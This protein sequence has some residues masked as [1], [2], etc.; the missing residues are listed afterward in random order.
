MKLVDSFKNLSI[1]L[2]GNIISSGIAIGQSYVFRQIELDVVAKNK[3]Q[4]EDIAAEQKRLEK[5]IAQSKNQINNIQ[6]KIAGKTSKDIE[7]IF[8]GHT[9]LLEDVDF[10]KN[11]NNLLIAEKVNIEY[12]LSNQIKIL[13]KKF[14]EIQDEFTQTR[15]I[16][17]QDVCY[18]LLRNLLGIEHV[19]TN[20]LRRIEEAVII[21]AERLRPS[22]I[23]L[24]D[25]KKIIGI[26]IEQGSTS[27]HVA[28]ISKSLGIPVVIN[29][30]GITSI[31]KTNHNIIIDGY[32]GIV[33]VNPKEKEFVFY[34]KK[35]D[36]ILISE[37]KNIAELENKKCETKDG[38]YIKLEANISTITEAKE[39]FLRG[40]QGIGL[41]RTEFFYIS[42]EKMPSIKEESDFYDEILNISKDRPVTIRLLDLG[43]DKALPYLPM[44]P[45]ESPQLGCRG[46]RFLFK[47][48]DIFK[49]Q[50]KSIFL[51]GKSRKIKILLPFIATIDDLEQAKKIINESIKSAK[52]KENIV[53]IGIMVEIPSMALSIEN[54]I[55]QVD[56]LSIGTNDL[57]QYVF[58]ANRES[59]NLDE[60]RQNTHPVLLNLI[61]KIVVCALK[62]NK[63]VVVCGEIAADP[64]SA[65]LLVGLGVRALSMQWQKIPA[66]HKIISKIC[67]KDL[68]KLAEKA[69]LLHKSIEV[70]NLL[71]DLNNKYEK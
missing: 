24:L 26:V 59:G 32:N 45:E 42:S 11:I 68:I 40:A 51:A 56:F 57:M 9:E 54:Y 16:D 35:K 21:V 63:E 22:D 29:I 3:F 33:I 23:G 46:I 18:R 70:I 61:K 69:L 53:Q 19:H 43:A 52:I 65:C 50:L 25:L 8:Q 71:K 49:K 1:E 6:L 36:D 13:E 2:K 64:L 28:I 10:L 62:Y 27:S 67:Y 39:A 31:V 5:A 12:I 34:Q 7:K 37:S 66:V 14:Y 15:F 4:I 38:V 58:A 47:Y 48:P 30:S 41:F 20:P 17:I 44:I 55:E 60:Y